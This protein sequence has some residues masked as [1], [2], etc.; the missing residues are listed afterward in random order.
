MNLKDNSR[1]HLSFWV[2]LSLYALIILGGW[3]LLNFASPPKDD[4]AL[5]TVPVTLSMFQP[6]A[7]PSPPQLAKP[8]PPQKTP[9]QPPVQQPKHTPKQ[10]P[11]AIPKKVQPEKK[12]A[13]KTAKPH[14]VVKP[15]VAQRQPLK[16]PQK[17]IIPPKKAEKP[18]KSIKKHQTSPAKPQKLPESPVLPPKTASTP[19]P[20]PKMVQNKPS[21][22]KNESTPPSTPVKKTA[23]KQ[24][25]Q[26][27]KAIEARYLAGLSQTLS[28]YAQQN[29]PHRAR[30]RHQQG[31]VVI[32][33]TLYPDGR[34]A[35]IQLA[36][37]SPHAQLN[38]AALS[39]LTEQMQKHYKPFPPELPKQ[40]KKIVVPI[41]YSLQ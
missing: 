17:P 21:R 41:Q 3:A 37:P 11:K 2:A 9:K 15:K 32:Q 24:D 27:I 34:I 18:Q 33:F 7:P 20:A 16:R 8:A 39:V 25:L 22:I 40:P 23:E 26:Q 1:T 14:P 31:K 35:N 28:R 19:S 38:Q 36:A 12:P 4:V 13:P 30:R 29:Y 6:P 5:K 10:P